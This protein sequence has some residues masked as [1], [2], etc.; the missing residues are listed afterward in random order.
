MDLTGIKEIH[1]EPTS[2]CN[3]ECPQCARN[4]NGTG[5]NPN[6]Q[7]GSLNLDWFERNITQSSITHIEKIFFCGNVGDP[8]ATPELIEI[9]R[10][11][12]AL[13]PE[14]T[15][16]ANTNGSLKTEQ[17]F[18]ELGQVLNGNLDYLV[19]SIDGLQD[20]NHIY[21]KNTR[22]SK[23]MQNAKAFI[24]TGASAHWDMLVFKHNR[25][26]VDSAK[27]LA[28]IM[29]FR[30]FRSKSTDRWD[31]YPIGDL[32]PASEYQKPNYQNTK[33]EC[34]RNR[35][36]SVFIDY[37]GKLW[38][39]CHMAE[40]HLNKIGEELHKDIKEFGSDQLMQEYQT[41]LDSEPFY[42]CRRACGKISGKRSQWKQEIQ[43]S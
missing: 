20:T 4:I 28:N 10:Y 5:L 13:K 23:I 27:D 35:D 24:S 11:L 12:K 36:S 25:H 33:P 34:E 17:W 37:T 39:C 7:L 40:A 6:I 8:C 22:W 30:W 9:I 38:P 41:R 1:I 29:G 31:T 26:Q 19:F 18:K 21:R 14:L 3:A 15:V 42:I 43:L 2:L 16:G 32:E